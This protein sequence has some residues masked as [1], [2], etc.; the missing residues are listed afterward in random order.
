M[1]DLVLEY[2]KYLMLLILLLYTILNFY[3]MLHQDPAWQNRICRKQ[4]SLVMMLN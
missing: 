2:S 1:V 4:M 3:V